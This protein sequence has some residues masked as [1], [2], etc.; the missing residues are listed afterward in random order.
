MNWGDIIK[1][2][3]F[4][5]FNDSNN[6]ND[7]NLN[8]LMK[9]KLLL[10]LLMLLSATMF[11]YK[12]E[13]I[14]INVNGQ[15]R[16]MICYTPSTA[17]ANMPLW[18]VTHGMNQDPEYQMG[19]DRLYELID[20][21]KF[22]VCYLRSDGSSWDIG[23]QKDLNFVRQTI[24]EMKAKYGIDT[25][26]VYWSGFSMGSM[27]IYHGIENGMA[28]VITAFAPCSGIK[29][30]EPWKNC[31]TPI[32]LIHCH[33]NGDEV[34]PIG[35]Y[36]PRDY[37]AHFA[38]E[39]DQC[40]TYKK[41]ENYRS[42]GGY[43]PGTKEVWTNGIN[44]TEVEILMC[45]N[46][47]HWPSVN[48]TRETW[49]FCRRFSKLTPAQSYEKAC[50]EAAK[51]LEQWEGDIEIFGSTANLK[52]NYTKLLTAMQTY[53]PDKV[54]ASDEAALKAAL[55]K[56]QTAVGNFTT[57]AESTKTTSKKVTKTEFDPNLHIYLCLGGDN[58]EGHD[59]PQLSDYAGSS[60]R[61]LMMP[62]VT[63]SSYKRSRGNWYVA[64]PPLCRA[65]TGIGIADYFGKALVRELPDSITVGIINVALDGCSIDVFNEDGLAAYLSQQSAGLQE[66]VREYTNNPFRRLVEMAQ[67]A[68]E[69]GV[70]KGI[71]LHQGEA[72]KG[73]Q[74][75]PR[76]VELVYSRLLKE[77]NL[78]RDEVPLLVGEMVQKNQGGTCWEHNS[79]ISNV[80]RMSANAYQVSSKNCA[81]DADGLHFSTEGYQKMGQNYALA[82]LDAQRRAVADDSHSVQSL[83][84]KYG[85]ITMLAGGGSSLC[86]MLTDEQG[87]QHDVTASCQFSC[88][89][90]GLLEFSALGM[91]SAGTEG[92]A[93]VTATYTNAE[94]KSAS[95]DFQVSVAMFPLSKDY[96]NP[97]I[98]KSGTITITTAS[99]RF[100]NDKGLGG[101]QFPD[102]L[103][104][105]GYKYLVANLVT[106]SSAK[107]ELR[108]Y[109]VND[110]NTSSYFAQAMEGVASLWVD[111]QE[112]K[113]ADGKA[114]DARHVCI[115][116][117]SPQNTGSVNID[118]VFVTNADMTVVKEIGQDGTLHDV[119]W[120][121]LSGRR[122]TPSQRG[123]YVRDG[124]K[125]MR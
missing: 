81:G 69:T 31:K 75:W 64:R 46:H 90:P 14:N 32:N 5:D 107:P 86:I 61:F 2:K 119:Q 1:F 33:G 11:A 52:T 89:N 97:S 36:Q 105:S 91:Q 57:S 77:L 60:M 96:F 7:F 103:D 44:G 121:D 24:T 98:L 65:A 55:E 79:V 58:M 113:D 15:S 67:K 112:M 18:I 41:I 118:G 35:Q 95:V 84:A 73:R 47:G 13:S 49:N 8:L 66:S 37:A 54:D 109:D 115:V 22:V 59:V 80:P 38:T 30:G 94:G 104:L 120:Y 39:V 62:A 106:N 16:N 25:N 63:M 93:T 51:L 34:F 12:Q 88:S 117:F 114:I 10:P 48:Y 68:Q 87:V 116:G 3:D 45:E 28:D 27:L 92:D 50:A 102:G 83:S 56:L 85:D 17:K 108:V 99:N 78:N 110:P 124:K 9:H 23:G 122:V 40:K 70:I 26:R 6:S 20:T 82:V 42:P 123:I 4:K 29:F 43:D 100:K 53:G 74:D 72:D 71:L 21:A 19:S 111:L 76:K 101:W 125:V